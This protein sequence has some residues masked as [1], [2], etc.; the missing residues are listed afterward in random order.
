M[1]EIKT[2][3]DDETVTSEFLED[4]TDVTDATIESGDQVSTKYESTDYES[5][6]NEDSKKKRPWMDKG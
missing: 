6:T 3:T 2:E 1:A 4:K 5:E